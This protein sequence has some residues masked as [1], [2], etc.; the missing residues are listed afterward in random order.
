MKPSDIYA[1]PPNF[2][3]TL[4][5][6]QSSIIEDVFNIDNLD[7]MEFDEYEKDNCPLMLM[8]KLDLSIDSNN[9]VSVHSVEFD[10]VPFAVVNHLGTDHSGNNNDVAVTDKATYE[11]AKAYVLSKIVKPF[12]EQDVVDIDA[13]LDWS[14][15]GAHI[16]KFGDETRLVQA[17]HVGYHAGTPVFDAQALEEAF[18]KNIRNS[19]ESTDYADGLRSAKMA[20]IAVEIISD[21]I[22]ADRK[23]MIGEFC[24]DKKWV[25]GFFLA[26]GEVYVASVTAHNLSTD[27]FYW[28]RKLDIKRICS[29]RYYDII[30]SYIGSGSVDKHDPMVKDFAEAFQLSHSEVE[31]AV[32][33]VT[34]GTGG[35]LL[36]A[37]VKTIKLRD[38]VPS[39]YQAGNLWVHARLLAETPR[40]VFFGFGDTGGIDHA[41]ELW[42]S[43]QAREAREAATELRQSV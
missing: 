37:A 23:L 35:D 33:L 25:A 7:D 43:R 29:G 5:W 3:E 15:H 28:H 20:K 39:D 16:A 12:Q 8:R 41:K 26:D 42:A 14:L 11:K 10:G 4:Y 38:E 13:E 9:W 40:L 31:H 18:D 27:S 19:K 21:A 32:N 36:S 30:A 24:N 22:L 17:H 34:Q 1:L 2:E 6:A